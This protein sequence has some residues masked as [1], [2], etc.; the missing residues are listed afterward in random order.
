MFTIKRQ[1][2]R[3]ISQQTISVSQ[4]HPNKIYVPQQVNSSCNLK[5]SFFS[6][7]RNEITLHSNILR[8]Y[9][10]INT[11]S[12]S[13][14]EKNAL[15]NAIKRFHHHHTKPHFETLLQEIECLNDGSNDANALKPIRIRARIHRVKGSNTS[16]FLY[17][18]DGVS[19]I[20]V[21]KFA[22]T[23]EDKEIIKQLKKISRESIIE[24][25]GILKKSEVL[26]TTQQ[27][28]PSIKNYEIELKSYKI[29]S[30]ADENCPLLVEDAMLSDALL[31][32]RE[33]SKGSKNRDSK[34]G[35]VTTDVRLD[36]RV[37]DLRVPAHH[38]ILKIQSKIGNL[39]REFLEKQNFIEI[40]TPKLV[41]TASEGG[42]NVFKVNY[43][44]RDAFLAQSPQLF[45]QMA[46]MSDCPGVYEI[47]PVFRAENS[48]TH[49]HLTEFVGLDIEMRIKDDYHEVLRLLD[50][51][52]VFIFDQLKEQCSKEIEIIRQQ[53]PSK[54]IVYRQNEPNLILN[55]KKA[56]D[57]L[58]EDGVTNENGELFGYYEDLTTP[59][60]KRLGQIVFEKYKTDFFIL[61][62]YPMTVRPFYT[63]PDE[64]NP[65][66]SKSYDI[67]LRG[68]EIAS[69]AQRIHDPEMLL[70]CAS[71][72]NVN[73]SPI[74]AYVNSFKYGAWPH[75]GAGFGLERLVFLYL[76]IGNVKRVNMFP[77]DPKSFDG[78][79]LRI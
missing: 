2:L 49:R 75:G 8:S 63:M 56:I 48:N 5:N 59:A 74:Q 73:L 47:G 60:E 62:K 15:T 27:P 24:V 6:A 12:F 68:E 31:A 76:G 18:R 77:R 72:K 13:F 23:E 30:L 51:A 22:E 44:G 45:K 21:V 10:I 11:P 40:H 50:K 67:F 34:R 7:S 55:Y 78:S 79:N 71:E 19:S 43:F 66:Y 26:I 57:I 53:Y 32:Q 16:C 33:S 37:I 3:Y 70:R 17:L 28:I 42:S 35:E 69:G 41:A 29:I 20:Q 39:F 36:N 61:D 58:R 52:F 64:E 4:C 54:D 1:A 65:G 46:I 9:S 14:K 38:C 25:D